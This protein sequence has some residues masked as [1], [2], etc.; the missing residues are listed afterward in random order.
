MG[1][2]MRVAIVGAVVIGGI[3]GSLAALAV[4]P[5]GHRP[6][7]MAARSAVPP[8][9]AALPVPAAPAIPDR[10]AAV[11]A[12]MQTVLRRFTDWSHDHAGEPC[13]GPA[14]LGGDA[15]DPWGHPL[16][17]TCTDQPAD[18]RIGAVSAGPD[19]VPGS[20][21]DIE[22]WSLGREITELVRGP[23]WTTTRLAGEKHRR[24]SATP[25]PHPRRPSPAAPPPP[26]PVADPASP[27]PPDASLDDIP[28]RR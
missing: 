23:R 12:A 25:S 10:Q 8:P 9:V 11:T 13:P 26:D 15:R 16:Q 28:A 14:A 5:P 20:D 2:A 18:Q 24:D 3:G 17:L 6:P 19:G 21:D 7:P 1:R 22:S 27:T 4:T